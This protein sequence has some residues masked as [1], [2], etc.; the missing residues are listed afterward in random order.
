M[1]CVC[2]ALLIAYVIYRVISMVCGLKK[3]QKDADNAIKKAQKFIW[4]N[5]NKMK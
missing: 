1:I 4:E 3:A 5:R 2:I